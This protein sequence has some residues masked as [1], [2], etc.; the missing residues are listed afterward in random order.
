ML[1]TPTG[2]LTTRIYEKRNTSK[3]SEQKANK[4]ITVLKSKDDM[5]ITSK[6]YEEII[7]IPMESWEKIV[8]YMH[9]LMKYALSYIIFTSTRTIEEFESRELVRRVLGKKMMV[10]DVFYNPDV[11]PSLH[12]PRIEFDP[13]EFKKFEIFFNK[14]KKRTSH[15]FSNEEIT[16]DFEKRQKE[17]RDAILVAQG[18]NNIKAIKSTTDKNKENEKKIKEKKLFLPKLLIKVKMIKKKMMK[19]K[20][21]IQEM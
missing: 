9:E 1:D 16:K 12:L 15:I 17:K 19:I 6:K 21:K 7:P 3:A 10:R 11:K 4:F 5:S 20:V 8:K 2:S 14:R 18:N 13:D